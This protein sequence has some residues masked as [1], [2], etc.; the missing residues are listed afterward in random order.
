MSKIHENHMMRCAVK[1]GTSAFRSP[2]SSWWTTRTSYPLQ[3]EA[4]YSYELRKCTE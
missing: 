3:Y 2:G 1:A 4:G